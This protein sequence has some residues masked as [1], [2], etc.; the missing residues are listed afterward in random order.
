MVDHF[1]PWAGGGYEISFQIRNSVKMRYHR[2]MIDN[3]HVLASKPCLTPTWW[4]YFPLD[5]SQ[6]LGSWQP[7]PRAYSSSPAKRPD[8]HGCGRRVFDQSLQK[9]RCKCTLQSPWNN[10]RSQTRW[11]MIKEQKIGLMPGLQPAS[12]DHKMTRDPFYNHEMPKN[13][14][15]HA[16]CC[17][18]TQTKGI[19][20]VT[21]LGTL[22]IT[23]VKQQL[24]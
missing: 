1:R 17:L 16:H 18:H 23:V 13:A 14:R 8:R 20:M 10:I 6:N 3:F 12:K 24:T 5:L 7:P 19:Y 2:H 22:S 11:N 9:Q 4:L 21:P 15:S